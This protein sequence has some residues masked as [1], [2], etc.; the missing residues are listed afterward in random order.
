MHDASILLSVQ[1]ESNCR[2]ARL[3]QEKRCN[4]RPGHMRGRKGP[5]RLYYHVRAGQARAIRA[6]RWRQSP[7]PH[8]LKDGTTKSLARATPPPRRSRPPRHPPHLLPPTPA[9]RIETPSPH[10]HG[11]AHAAR[12]TRHPCCGQCL[13]HLPRR[14]PSLACHQRPPCRLDLE[15]RQHHHWR[16]PRP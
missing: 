5:G 8:L 15:R 7:L 4:G 6:T 9:A 12:W 16:R 1:T 10:R 3:L 11:T 14:P 13:C 2:R